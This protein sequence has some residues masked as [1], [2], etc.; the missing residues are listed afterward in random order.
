MFCDFLKLFYEFTVEMSKSEYPTLG[1][2]LLFL[3]H[4]EEHPNTTIQDKETQ[5]P[6]WI[7]DIAKAM[8]VKFDSLSNN[9]NNS[10]AYLT[11]IL[12]PRYKTQIVPNNIDIEMAKNTLLTEFNNYQVLIESEK[13]NE[14]NSI[15]TVKL[16]EKRKPLGIMECILQKKKKSNNLSF[17]NK[18]EEYLVNPCE[19][20]RDH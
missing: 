6:V 3:D 14:E 20:W 12:D 16:G 9:L 19:W 5:I 1:M 17:N 15:L 8:K 7:K 2:L 10:A 13:N 11:L 4:L 18:V